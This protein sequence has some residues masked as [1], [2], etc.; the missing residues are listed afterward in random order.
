MVGLTHW[1]VSLFNIETIL[2]K[3]IISA[4]ENHFFL[5]KNPKTKFP[6]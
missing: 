5:K 1:M 4:V 6:F 2:M 3:A